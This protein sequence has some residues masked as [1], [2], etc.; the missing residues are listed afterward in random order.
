MNYA[1]W[2][3]CYLYLGRVKERNLASSFPGDYEDDEKKMYSLGST[4]TREEVGRR[5]TKRIFFLMK[6]KSSHTFTWS[7]TGLVR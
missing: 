2:L 7:R 5:E 4:L 1:C 3:S 6:S